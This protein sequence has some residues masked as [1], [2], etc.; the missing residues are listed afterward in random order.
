[1]WSRLETFDGL[2]R[3]EIVKTL[4]KKVANKTSLAKAWRLC[5]RTS[6]GHLTKGELFGFLHLIKLAQDGKPLPD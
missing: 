5:C 6:R 4:Y 3:G 1:M 2:V